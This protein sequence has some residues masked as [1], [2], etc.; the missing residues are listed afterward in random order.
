[1]GTI[2]EPAR[3]VRVTSFDNNDLFALDETGALWSYERR[4][5]LTMWIL[6]PR[7]HDRNDHI[8]DLY[9]HLQLNEDDTAIST[10]PA[11]RVLDD[12]GKLWELRWCN[13]EYLWD[14]IN[15]GAR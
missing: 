4:Q 8:V 12:A 3:I 13:G 14:S 2:T 9:V 7:P 6:L 15:L 1:M 11:L 10:T 5:Y